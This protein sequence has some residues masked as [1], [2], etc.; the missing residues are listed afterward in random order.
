MATPKGKIFTKSLIGSHTVATAVDSNNVLLDSWAVEEDVKIIGYY[1]MADIGYK[2]VD[3]VGALSHDIELTFAAAMDNDA[4]FARVST[5]VAGF[6]ATPGSYVLIDR[7]NFEMFPAG[8]YIEAKEGEIINMLNNTHNHT[9]ADV[10][11]IGHAIIYYTK[12]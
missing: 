6:G 11:Y 3:Y 5:E 12:G 2:G 10:F 8:T 1:L 7:E 9:G 4:R